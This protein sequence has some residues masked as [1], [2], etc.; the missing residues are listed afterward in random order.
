MPEGK[1]RLTANEYG[2]FCGGGQWKYSQ[3]IMAIIAQFC[4]YTENHWIL[5]FK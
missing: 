4:E 2:C 5:Q 3:L 1:C